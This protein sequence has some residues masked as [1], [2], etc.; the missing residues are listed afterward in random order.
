MRVAFW[1]KY[2]KK[3]PEGGLLSRD[4]T[5]IS[6]DQVYSSAHKIE[7]NLIVPKNAPNRKG[8][9]LEKRLYV[10]GVQVIIKLTVQHYCS[11]LYS[12]ASPPSTSPLANGLLPLM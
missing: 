7:L 1:F 9:F 2:N 8:R 3:P 6:S 12:G 10:L 4:E 11:T 5:A